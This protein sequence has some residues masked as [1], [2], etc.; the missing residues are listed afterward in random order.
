MCE[1]CVCGGE[2]RPGG[3]PRAGEKRGSKPG[4]SGLFEWRPAPVPAAT[5]QQKRGVAALAPASEALTRA[6]RSPG[7]LPTFPPAGPP[8]LPLPPA[9]RRA[10]PPPPAF[11]LALPCHRHLPVKSP[12]RRR[13]HHH[14]HH[15]TPHHTP[16]NPTSQQTPAVLP[17]SGR[18]PPP[19]SA[20]GSSTGGGASPGRCPVLAA[21]AYIRAQSCAAGGRQQGEGGASTGQGAGARCSR[22]TASGSVEQAL[23]AGNNKLRPQAAT[24]QCAPGAPARSPLVAQPPTQFGQWEGCPAGRQA[25]RW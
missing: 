8:A 7:L 12:A 24:S 5:G 4:C 10:R 1:G 15:H 11:C 25:G 14:H 2:D 9:L 19:P 13:R 3:L 23:R 20:A 18:R 16:H 6:P 17:A 22:I 21:T